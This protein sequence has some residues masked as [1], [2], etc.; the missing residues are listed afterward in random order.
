MTILSRASDKAMSLAFDVT[1][2]TIVLAAICIAT[3]SEA[4]RLWKWRDDVL[5]GEIKPRAARTTE[6]E[7][8]TLAIT[9]AVLMLC[10]AWIFL[11]GTAG[12]IKHVNSTL[13]HKTVQTEESTE[14]R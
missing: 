7:A 9:C 3:A 13:D 14:R 10:T 5:C 4:L 2:M 8:A 12:I 1:L 6:G 11:V